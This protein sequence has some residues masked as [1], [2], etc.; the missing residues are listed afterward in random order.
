MGRRFYTD[1]IVVPEPQQPALEEQVLYLPERLAAVP[2][3][4]QRVKARVPA[5]FMLSME[6]ERVITQR[7]SDI[8]EPDPSYV[9]SSDSWP[10]ETDEQTSSSSS[11]KAPI[12][13]DWWSGGGDGEEAP[14]NRAG[15]S[16][17]V[18]SYA[19]PASLRTLHAN[20]ATHVGE[21]SLMALQWTN[22]CG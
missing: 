8:F 3:R 4:R 5:K 21:D 15:G 10:P 1:D 6:E 14:N 19:S 13:E 2:L 16:Y 18:A 11:P 7:F 9:N 17:T 12:E 22:L 20:L